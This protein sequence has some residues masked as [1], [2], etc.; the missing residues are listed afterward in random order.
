MTDKIISARKRALINLAGSP[1]VVG[2]VALGLTSFLGAWAISGSSLLNFLGVVGILIGLGIYGTKAAFCKDVMIQTSLKDL[3]RE[4]LVKQE[5]KLDDLDHKLRQTLKGDRFDSRDENMLRDLRSIFRGFKEDLENQEFT[6]Q[7]RTIAKTIDHLFHACIHQLNASWSVWQRLSRLSARSPARKE[8]K[9]KRELML[10]QV[11]ESIEKIQTT[12]E[13]FHNFKIDE[14]SMSLQDLN[15][16]LE[17]KMEI[18]KQVEKEMQ[19]LHKPT[20]RIGD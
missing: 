11:K 8:L 6:E 7:G 18:A 20:T 14:T 2:P 5:Q 13:Q 17:A 4:E 16:E 12:V 19:E 3:Q 15:K 1:W 10:C 9:E